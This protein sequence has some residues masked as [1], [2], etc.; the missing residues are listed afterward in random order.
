MSHVG[1]P[2]LPGNARRLLVERFGSREVLVATHE[3]NQLLHRSPRRETA[4][5]EAELDLHDDETLVSVGNRR[6]RGT[7]AHQ[8]A[9]V[10]QGIDARRIGF[11][12]RLD[13]YHDHNRLRGCSAKTAPAPG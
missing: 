4:V 7:R 12:L 9:R 10:E 5:V 11:S 13:H 6:E 8:V 3:L 1:L 2:S